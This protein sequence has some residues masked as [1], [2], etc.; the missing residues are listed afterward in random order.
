MNNPGPQ[1]IPF[2]QLRY[3]RGIHDALIA[4]GCQVHVP[5][6]G[7]VSSLETRARQLSQYI[8]ATANSQYVNLIAHS[9]VVIQIIF[10]SFVLGRI[11]L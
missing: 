10:N 7:T 5:R 6:V 4:I 2:L 1:R 3:W 9:M 11:G 8:Q